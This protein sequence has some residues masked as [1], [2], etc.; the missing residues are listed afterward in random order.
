MINIPFFGLARQYENLR[1]EILAEVNKI[2]SSGRVLGGDQTLN[3]ETAIAGR[4]HRDYAVSVNSASMGLFLAQLALNLTYESIV[5]PTISFAATLNAVLMANNIP[6]YCD[7]DHHGLIDLR[8]L[9]INLKENQIK[10]LMYVNLFGNTVDYDR[11]ELMAKFFNNDK[12]TIIEDAAQ[13]FGAYYKGVPSGKLGD[14]SVLSFDPT[15]NLPNYGSGGMVLTDNRAIFF[16]IRDLARNGKENNH[17][18]IGT[19]SQ[20]SEA[21]CAAMM[22]KLKY[23]DEWQERRKKIAE[24]YIDRLKNYVRVTEVSADVEH[25]W[26]KFPV[27]IEDRG[28][29]TDR[30]LQGSFTSRAIL[31]GKL[32]EYGIDTRIH[33]VTPL[34]ELYCNPSGYHRNLIDSR[35]SHAEQ[36]CRTELSL[37][38][39][40]ELTDLEVE[41][42]IDQL[43]DCV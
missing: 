12:V 23:F 30:G 18:F 5:L 39:Y 24:F 13:S 9:N 6:V 25:A 37:P 40:P 41:Y 1:E 31:M 3:F 17:D 21:D 38:I 19:N 8:N 29:D 42:I 16:A 27:W 20:M 14:I 10:A 26:H 28:Y 32:S 11:L 36:H 35:Y 2:Y 34:P 33:Y 22:V 15:K 4:C 43:L 7:V